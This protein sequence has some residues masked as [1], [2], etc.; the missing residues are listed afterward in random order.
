M[1]TIIEG[2]YG[3]NWAISKPWAVGDDENEVAI[4]S[5]DAAGNRIFKVSVLLDAM[6]AEG[7][8]DAV[9]II[10]ELPKI[11]PSGSTGYVSAGSRSYSATEDWADGRKHR[12]VAMERL[13]IARYLEA[14]N[15]EAARAE[16]TALRKHRQRIV[17][18]HS[19]GL[20]AYDYDSL[21]TNG[22][23]IVD[24]IR[25]LEDQLAAK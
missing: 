10:T 9:E 22:K 4:N 6:K 2:T 25:E 12:A 5:L 15:S 21:D 19:N 23:H 7:V 18:S 17:N 14:K 24:T 13:A 11:G 3:S 1:S 20:G 8:L 16:E